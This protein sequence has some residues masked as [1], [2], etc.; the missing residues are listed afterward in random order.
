VTSNETGTVT[1]AT[2]TAE[3]P[4]ATTVIESTE[5]SVETFPP[6]TLSGEGKAVEEFTIPEGSAAIAEITHKG[7]SNFS[8]Q[9]VDTSGDSVD[10]LVNEIGDYI[11]TVLLNP[12]EGHPVAFEVDA[13]GPWT[14]DVKPVAEAQVWDLSG[15]LDETGDSVVRLVPPSAGL[16]SLELTYD[17]EDNFIVESYSGLGWDVLANEIGEFTGEV[18]LPDGT[19]LLEVTA[20]GGTWTATPG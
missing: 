19:F 18:L 20:N 2:R 7:E 6:I 11:G 1:P 12:A 9:T 16:N 10:L 13:D 15:T 17:G 4:E 5:P 14:M 8:V 3:V